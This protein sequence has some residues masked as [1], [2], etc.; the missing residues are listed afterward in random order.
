MRT[1]DRQLALQPDGI[2]SPSRSVP[3]G[4]VDRANAF[5]ERDREDPALRAPSGRCP[6]DFARLRLAARALRALS[7]STSLG[8]A[9]LRAPSGRFPFD[10][11]R[12][13]LAARALRALARS[14][15]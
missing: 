7:V 8:F 9:S 11:A 4:T 13:R 5:A 3:I 12:L 1:P 14:P 2:Q 10:F 6:F 15:P